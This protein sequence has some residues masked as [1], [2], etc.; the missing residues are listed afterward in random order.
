VSTKVQIVKRLE[1]IKSLIELED[2]DMI[3]IQIDK[4]K[5]EKNDELSN[6]IKILENHQCP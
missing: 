3:H 2:E 1:I 5:S 6:I 4:L